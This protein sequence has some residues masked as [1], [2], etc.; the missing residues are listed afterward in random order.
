M[1][2]LDVSA[3]SSKG[4][5]TMINII[6]FISIAFL[7]LSLSG[8]IPLVLGGYI[9][10]KMAQDD[11]HSEWCATHEHIGDVSCGD[12]AVDFKYATTPEKIG[13]P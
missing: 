7:A 9:G 11:A 3:I 12:A 8:C 13:S 10:Y 1:A 4:H 5:S 6:K 2:L